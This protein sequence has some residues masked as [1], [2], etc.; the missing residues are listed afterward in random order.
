M[1]RFG[2]RM[3]QI[4][5]SFLVSLPK[6]W[7]KRNNLKKGNMVLI[8]VNNDNSLSLFSSDVTGEE[9][10]EVTIVYSQTS[11]DNIVNQ[12]YGTYLL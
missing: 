9:P 1:L 10:K 11:V 2:R 5:S 4:G 12:I 8:E 7:V 6:G 3:Q